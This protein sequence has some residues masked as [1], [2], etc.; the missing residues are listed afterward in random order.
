MNTF[1]T[2]IDLQPSSFRISHKSKILINGSC[3]ADNIGQKLSELRFKIKINPFGV[4]YNPLSLL[5]GLGILLDG[6]EFTE[7]DLSFYNELWFSWDHHSSFS[8]P[9]KEICLGKINGETRNSAKHLKKTD[10]L[11]IT[12]GTSWAYRLKKTGEIVS[13]CHKVPEK[14]FDRIFLNPQDI[15]NSWKVF[16]PELLMK[17]PGMKIIFTVSPV[18]HWKDGAHGNQLSKSSLLLA[19]NDLCHI[20]PGFTEYFPSY[21]ILL[22]DLRDYRFYDDDL[23]HPNTQA[24]NYIWSIFSNVYFDTKTL[25]I[26]RELEK[27]NQSMNHRAYN[28]DTEAYLKFTEKLNK[29]TKELSEKYPFLG[30]QGPS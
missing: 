5:N 26:N 18:R 30:L 13:N 27:L 10:F 25:E 24:V 15:V 20:F 4:V 9:S 19:I 29:K 1:R 2:E 7:E 16:I 23:F 14:E 17:N 21:E 22:D 12:F 28:K 3:F 8:N 6:E 11:I